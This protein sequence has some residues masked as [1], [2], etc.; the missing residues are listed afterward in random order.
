MSRYQCKED[1]VQQ[2]WDKSDRGKGRRS[3][4]PWSLIY[5]EIYTLWARLRQD[6]KPRKRQTPHLSSMPL[7]P[8]PCPKTWC[9]RKATVAQIFCLRPCQGSF[10]FNSFNHRGMRSVLCDCH[11]VP[12]SWNILLF[13]KDFPTD[14]GQEKICMCKPWQSLNDKNFKCHGLS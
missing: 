8:Q 7:Y 1:R 11:F 2:G 10:F 6:T 5:V 9:K 3:V 4:A 13:T 14:L 12:N